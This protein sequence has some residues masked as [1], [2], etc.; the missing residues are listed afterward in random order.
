MLGISKR[1]WTPLAAGRRNCLVGAIPPILL[2][3]AI[4]EV[5]V[6]TEHPGWRTDDFLITCEASDVTVSR[7]VGPAK[8][9]FTVSASDDDCKKD[10]F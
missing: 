2:D 3:G 1:S 9:T 10:R 4:A 8:R 6:Q 5:A 7:L